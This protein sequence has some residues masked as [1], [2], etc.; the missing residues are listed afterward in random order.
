MKKTFEN[1]IKEYKQELY[2]AIINNDDVAFI[3][4]GMWLVDNWDNDDDELFNNDYPF[5]Y[6]FDEVIVMDI[7]EVLEVTKLKDIRKWAK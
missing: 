5:N 1:E 4:A 6:S 3:N 7:D 2:N